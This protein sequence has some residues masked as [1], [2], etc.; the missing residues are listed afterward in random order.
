M[1]GESE[2]VVKAAKWIALVA[3]VSFSQPA[4]LAS[5]PSSVRLEIDADQP[6]AKISRDIFGQF[7]EHLGSGIYGGIWVGPELARAQRP[8]NPQRRGCRT[9]RNSRAQRALARRLLWRQL[10]LAQRHRPARTAACDPQ[11]GLGRSDRAQ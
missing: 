2:M 6:G 5:P 7:A 3:T 8:W 10:S 1:S 9:A 4:A 11:P